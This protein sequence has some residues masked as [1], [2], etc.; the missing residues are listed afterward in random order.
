MIRK[1]EPCHLDRV[2]QIWLDSNLDAHNFVPGKYWEENAGVVREQLL[3]AEV[4]VYQEEGAVLG[5]A[6]LQNHY[7]AGIFVKKG[8]RSRGIGKELL[9][10]I[11]SLYPDI[12]LNVYKKNERAA[13]FY[14]REGFKIV[15]E[16]IDKDIGERELTMVWE[17]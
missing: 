6:G 11:K 12:C 7:L 2:M 4:Y 3:Q 1:M 10:Y 17:H 9:S 5:F 15:S 16:N 14:R 13:D 8:A